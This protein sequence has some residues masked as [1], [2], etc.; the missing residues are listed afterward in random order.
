MASGYKI[1]VKGIDN[2]D[3][4]FAQLPKQTQNGIENEMRAVGLSWVSAAKSDAPVDRARLKQS[5]SFIV[6]RLSL[7]I[8]AQSE[9]AAY[10]EFGTKGKVKVPATLGSYPNEF[11]GSGESNVDPIQALTEWVR[12]KGLAATYSVK[13]RRRTGRS[14]SEER[15]ERTIAYL[16]WRKIRKEGVKPQPF[17]FTGKDGSDRIDFYVEQIRKNIAAMLQQ[18]I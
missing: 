15:L 11:R 18:I 14:V 17:L 16:V 10:M 1:E 7:T 3:K 9:H 8:V 13:T 6:D 2:L 12:R 4:V 5:I